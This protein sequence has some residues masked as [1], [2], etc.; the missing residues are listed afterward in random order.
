MNRSEWQHSVANGRIRRKA[1]QAVKLDSAIEELVNSRISPQQ[2]I[3][4]SVSGLW[5]SLL[6]AELERHCKIDD[7]SEGILKARV[8]SPP[9][10]HELRLCSAELLEVLQKRCPRARIKMIKIFLA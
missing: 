5:N 6:P 3:F 1:N 2:K 4:D 8:D 10:M 9:Y 7:I